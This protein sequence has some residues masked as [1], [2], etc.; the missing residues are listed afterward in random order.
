M[1]LANISVRK[2]LEHYSIILYYQKMFSKD[3]QDTELF[4][5][6]GALIERE[7]H[8]Q[9]TLEEYRN[10]ASVII[11]GSRQGMIEHRINCDILSTKLRE[12]R[13]ELEF[14]ERLVA[15]RFQA[16]KLDLH[17]T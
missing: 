13:R 12:V 17:R 3:E 6:Y 2:H 9:G 5:K 11:N 14:H 1:K 10:D 7:K 4:E 16:G 15:A 8:L